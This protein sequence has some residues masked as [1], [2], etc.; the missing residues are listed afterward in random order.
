MQLAKVVNRLNNLRGE[1]LIKGKFIGPRKG[2]GIWWKKNII[3]C[4]CA[5]VLIGRVNMLR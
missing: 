4:R 2:V 5:R 1:G 3:I